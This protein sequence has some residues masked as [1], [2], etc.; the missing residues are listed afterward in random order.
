MATNLSSPPQP[1]T[2]DLTGL[3]ESVVEWVMRI[4]SGAR[5]Q[6]GTGEAMAP[7][8]LLPR[9]QWLAEYAAWKQ[10]AAGR[11]DRYPAD[12]VLDDSRDTIYGDRDRA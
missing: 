12:H 7:A 6:P 8:L 1:R 3:P 4:V 5:L 10:S 11:A 2:V 9:E